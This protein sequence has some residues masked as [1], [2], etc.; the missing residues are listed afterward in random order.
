M[1]RLSSS[2][3]KTFYRAQGPSSEF[4]QGQLRACGVEDQITVDELLSS[5]E[6]IHKISLTL[7]EGFFENEN[8][9]LL[10]IGCERD[11]LPLSRLQEFYHCE[12]YV[13]SDSWTNELENGIE[14]PASENRLIEWLAEILSGL[15]IDYCIVDVEAFSVSPTYKSLACANTFALLVFEL[16]H[17]NIKR[18]FRSICLLHSEE[19]NL[20]A[21]DGFSDFYARSY[22][23]LFHSFDEFLIGTAGKGFAE[24][25]SYACMTSKPIYSLWADVVAQAPE[26]ERPHGP[27]LAVVLKSKTSHSI[28]ANSIKN[29]IFEKLSINGF[30]IHVVCFTHRPDEVQE[31]SKLLAHLENAGAVELSE[32]RAISAVIEAAK[33]SSYIWMPIDTR[34]FSRLISVTQNQFC[35]DLIEIYM[36]HYSDLLSENL[37]G[38]GASFFFYRNN[39]EVMGAKVYA[40]CLSELTHFKSLG[41]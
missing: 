38:L 20:Q 10:Y 40:M 12:R 34:R 3:Q 16:L 11:L 22:Q 21:E 31:I 29:R 18:D 24:F 13:R 23:A 41:E 8:R 4:V 7:S 27:S 39:R 1:R 2:T 35:K 25:L 26:E 28:V 19:L 15:S 32:V 5:V 17:E 37:K 36:L 14:E 33:Q 9:R 6:N 30:Q